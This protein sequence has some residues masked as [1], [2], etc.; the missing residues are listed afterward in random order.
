MQEAETVV[1]PTPTSTV[2]GNT[3]TQEDSGFKRLISI[4]R[5]TCREYYATG[6]GVPF[7][8]RWQDA[9]WHRF[10]DGE[11]AFSV[12]VRDRT[13]VSALASL[14]ATTIFEAYMLNHLDFRGDME[15]FYSFRD[16]TTD[17]HPLRYFW[18]LIKPLVFGQTKMDR[19][20]IASHYDHSQ[21]FYLTF[22]DKRHRCYSQGVFASDD[23]SL[24]DAMTRK[25]DFAIEQIGAKPGDKVLDIGGGWGAFNEYAGKKGI[26]VTSL[27]ISRESEN[28]LNDMI[29]REKIPTNVVN[30]HLY[31]YD[32]GIKYDGLV[33]LGVTEHLP[34]YGKSLAT[35]ERLLKPGRKIYLD[36]SAC[37]EKYK[38]H[39][40]IYRYIYPNNC[41]PMCL[42][43]YATQLAKT[44][45][46][47]KGIWDDRW[48]YYL[49]AKHWA[50]NF[51][52]NRDKLVELEG[53]ILF[54]QF[55]LYL[56]GTA[57]VFKKDVMQA[58]RWVLQLPE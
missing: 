56:W 45:F 3:A 46:Q 31:E 18:S 25:M 57:D 12:T 50:Q 15:R 47:L 23:E 33:N 8:I 49:T 6:K 55:Q 10:G 41:S 39:S 26:H 14:D 52:K 29:A 28:Y 11:A 37:R 4:L 40:F 32:P 21:E 48:N 5:K 36:A 54:R 20:G 35:Y 22:M 58:Y 24:E 19:A 27:T 2:S 17:N 43:D 9:E 53:E 13:A 16:M 38:F 1:A 34:D 30:C 7:Q 44:R 42:H 51:E